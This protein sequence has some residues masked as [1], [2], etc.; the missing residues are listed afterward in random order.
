MKVTYLIENL[1][2]ILLSEHMYFLTI[3]PRPGRI[4]PYLLICLL[5]NNTIHSCYDATNKSE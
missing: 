3:N 1:T 5:V 2:Y 4:F